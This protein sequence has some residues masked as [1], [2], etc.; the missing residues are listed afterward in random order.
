MSSDPKSVVAPF[1]AALYDFDGANLAASLSVFAQASIKLAHPLGE[2]DVSGLAG[3]YAGLSKAWPDFERRESGLARYSRHRAVGP[4]ALSRV[5][6]DRR[7]A[8]RRD[9]GGLGSP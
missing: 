8:S 6:Q 4:H 5:L 3:V 9:A 2:M 1:R 7:G